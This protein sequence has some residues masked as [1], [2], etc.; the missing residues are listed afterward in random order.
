MV[1]IEEAVTEIPHILTFSSKC[2]ISFRINESYICHNATVTPSLPC[3]H[4]HLSFMK[5][6][7]YKFIVSN[8]KYRKPLMASLLHHQGT[9]FQTVAPR[10]ITEDKYFQNM[11]SAPNTQIVMCKIGGIPFNEQ[12]I[13]KILHPIH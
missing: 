4:P 10:R 7:C 6:F 12:S 8:L 1:R 5:D 13:S 11:N 9:F 3:K 2:G